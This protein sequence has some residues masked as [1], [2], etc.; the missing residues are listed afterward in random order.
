[1]N[2]HSYLI[3]SVNGHISRIEKVFQTNIEIGTFL[4]VNS[5]VP[6]AYGELRCSIESEKI[7]EN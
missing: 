5:T 7:S 2:G 4:F 3:T 1:M 6:Y